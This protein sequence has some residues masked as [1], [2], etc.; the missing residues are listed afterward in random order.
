M[1]V[2]R[3]IDIEKYYGNLKSIKD[4]YIRCG[5]QSRFSGETEFDF[6]TWRTNSRNLLR[7]ILG[8]DM[9]ET[10][11]LALWEHFDMGDPGS[12]IAPRPLVIQS[13][14]DDKLNGSRGM[15][16]VTEQVDIIRNAYRLLGKE[17]NLYNDI[18]PGGHSW[19]KV[20]LDKI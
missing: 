2:K 15:I 5:R 9:P 10:C 18:K 14:I 17:S 1:V 16:N 6:E 7:K 3:I 8:L 11:N 12:M 4:R 13:C 20:D 19:H